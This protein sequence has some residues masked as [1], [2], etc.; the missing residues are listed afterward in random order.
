MA[1]GLWP[2]VSEAIL[3][4]CP[5]FAT[6]LLLGKTRREICYASGGAGRAH[7]LE[8]PLEALVRFLRSFP[9]LTAEQMDVAI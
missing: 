2:L 6:N 3:F 7:L 1:S 4:G 8:Y 5:R 9:V